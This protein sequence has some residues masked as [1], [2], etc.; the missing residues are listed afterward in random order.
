[1]SIWTPTR[2]ELI[3][4]APLV[5]GATALPRRVWAAPASNVLRLFVIGDW[6]RAGGHYQRDVANAM[7]AS[8]P[9]RYVLSTGDNFYQWGVKSVADE[10]WRVSFH[11]I[12][13]PE[14]REAE[15]YAVL[16]NHDWAGST[17]AQIDRTWIDPRWRL[18]RHYYKLGPDE[19]GVPGIDIFMIDTTLWMGYETVPHAWK[20]D[21]PKGLDS[22]GHK[23]WLTR[24][25]EKSAAPMKLVVGHHP[26]YSVGPHGGWRR[27]SDLDELFRRTGVA[28]YICGHDH[29][30]YHIV[31]D[32]LHYIC[33]G[34]GS[35]ILPEYT[36]G[37]V[38]GCVLRGH[39][40]D[41]DQP[42]WLSFLGQSWRPEYDLKG[43]FAIFEVTRSGAT[44]SFI[45]RL[46][47]QRHRGVISPRAT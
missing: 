34:A 7:N 24:E 38:Y 44:F 15:W 13:H 20:G 28:A 4:T 17:Q 31:H 19:L 37:K 25:L 3:T 11:D 47:V 32:G 46:R 18:P 1:M 2:R 29:G 16:G 14:A 30:M 8:G 22:R 27:L 43:G 36:G 21:T 5:L 33:S 40:H 10:K 35:Q 45:D 9:P 26:I 6:G 23:E 39:C 12:Y 42:R 41:P